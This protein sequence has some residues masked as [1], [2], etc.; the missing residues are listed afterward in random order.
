LHE[1]EARNLDAE[2]S[3]LIDPR[4]RRYP[5]LAAVLATRMSDL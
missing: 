1:F 2:A 4:T 3:Q 5:H